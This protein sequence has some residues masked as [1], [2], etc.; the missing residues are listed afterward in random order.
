M[1]YKLKNTKKSISQVNERMYY[2]RVENDPEFEY[3][4]YRKK[5]KLTEFI[6]LQKTKNKIKLTQFKKN[7]NISDDI[8]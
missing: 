1:E 3:N 8:S 7:K 2:S 6:V 5:G 4:V